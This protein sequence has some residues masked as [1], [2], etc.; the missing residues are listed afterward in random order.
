MTRPRIL[1]L[2]QFTELEWGISPL[3]EKWADVASFDAPGVGNEPITEQEL[4]GMR[5]GS[6]RLRDLLVRRGL[7]EVERRGWDSY[8]IAGDAWSTAP[9]AMIAAERAD[10]VRGLALGHASIHYSMEGERPAV[11]RE[12][13]AAMRQLLRQNHDDFLRH[14]IV[15]M[16]RGSVDDETAR[17][18]IARFPDQDFMEL[19]WESLGS[20]DTPLEELLKRYS[21]PLLL[22][23]H[24]GCLSFTDEGFADATASFPEA[25]VDRLPTAI[26][27]APEFD[28]ILR[29]FCED[30][31]ARAV[32]PVSPRAG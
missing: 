27:A 28:S 24:V 30:V 19:V 14:G 12:V 29:R 13:W 5:D 31:E 4:D 20:E 22:V 23:Q 7:E 8:F 6:L 9:A 18:M 2:P 3:L 15:Q 16:T 11:S 1:L 32:G 26:G 21:G 25:A 17:E 10:F